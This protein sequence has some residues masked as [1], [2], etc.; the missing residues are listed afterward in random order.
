M[1]NVKRK[2][3]HFSKDYGIL[4][5]MVI[6]D[7]DNKNTDQNKIIQKSIKTNSIFSESNFIY[8]RNY[9]GDNKT[10]HPEP[11]VLKAFE[12]AGLKVVEVR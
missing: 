1:L 4:I 12:K 3:L 10:I 6:T 11:N 5:E 9:W 8:E 7:I 2:R